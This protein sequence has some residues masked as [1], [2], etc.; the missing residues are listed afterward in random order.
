MPTINIVFEPEAQA[1]LPP[2]NP[3]AALSLRVAE[4]VREQLSEKPASNLALPTGRT[5]TGCYRVLSDWYAEG[6]LDWSQAT[7]FALDEYYD[8]DERFSFRHYLEDH[9]YQQTNLR[10]AARFNPILAADYDGVIAA[11]G[12]LDLALLGIG[13]NGHIAFNEPGTPLDSWTHSVILTDSTRKAN[14]EFFV[15]GEAPTR[16]VTVGLQT[17]LAA[18]KVILIASGEQKRQI[19]RRALSEPVTADVPASFLQL[20]KQLVLMTD[21]VV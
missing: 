9:L 16:A 14:A 6:K 13:N 20:H 21:F 1:G 8:V 18:K 19:L 17:I 10:P 5:P 15:N 7:A 11:A 3:Y 12:G 2:Q 4:L